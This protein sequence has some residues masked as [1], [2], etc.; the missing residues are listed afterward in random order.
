MNNNFK[1][2]VEFNVETNCDSCKA[3]V[4]K[5]L[6][7]LT[8]ITI[9]YFDVKQQ[10]L[11][12]ELNESSNHSIEEI[13]DLIESKAGIRTV[14]KG[15]GENKLSSVSE[16][17]GPNNILGVVRLSQLFD[18]I[19]LVDGVIDGINENECKAALNIHEYGDLSGDNFKNVGSVYV[20]ILPHLKSVSQRSSFRLQISNCDL[21]CCIGRSMVVSD[22][23]N[24]RPLAAGIIA[25]ASPVG[26]NTKKICV[27]SGKTL[28]EERQEKS[29][30]EKQSP[31]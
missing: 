19:C 26:G 25:R 31:I 17:Q 20:P 13:R 14:I 29:K 5:V 2:K 18:N 7:N 9:D 16:I 1:T 24:N 28:W 10:R 3:K 21:S 4:E 27:C 8:G 15:L 30:V 22:T 6:S 23:R 11:I 12:V